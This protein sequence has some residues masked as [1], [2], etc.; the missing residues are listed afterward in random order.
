MI[1]DSFEQTDGT[2]YPDI[3]TVKDCISGRGAFS[4]GSTYNKS[5]VYVSIWNGLSA[6]AI[7]IKGYTSTQVCYGDPW[8]G[9]SPFM[10]LSDMQDAYIGIT[11]CGVTQ[12][13]IWNES[14]YGFTN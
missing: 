3:E 9:T 10:T 8:D 6:H 4:S 13:F 5:P 11:S 1:T 2:T 7:F 14:Y 12:K